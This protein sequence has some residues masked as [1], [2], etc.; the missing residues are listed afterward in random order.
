MLS[1]K[2]LNE[3]DIDLCYKL[4]SN[5]ISLWSKKQWA[6]EFQKEG[7][8]EFGLLI[9]NL[10]IFFW[11]LVRLILWKRFEN[12]LNKWK[13]W[14]DQS[15]FERNGNPDYK[16]RPPYLTGLRIMFVMQNYN[17]FNVDFVN[18]PELDVPFTKVDLEDFGGIQEVHFT[19]FVL[20]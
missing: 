17:V 13:K 3:K 19:S 11:S 14:F 9:S 5:T 16:L 2:K 1:G 6:N 7:I 15:K 18:N 8:K 20:Q 4:D 10:L 12:N